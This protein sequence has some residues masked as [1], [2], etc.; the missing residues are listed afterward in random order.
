MT[1]I[2][3]RNNRSVAQ[4]RECRAV[5]M[6]ELMVSVTLISFIILTLYQMFNITQKQ[7]RR[8]MTQVDTLE[9]GRVAKLMLETDLKLAAALDSSEVA[10]SFYWSTNWSEH[11]MNLT[12]VTNLTITSPV[13]SNDIVLVP[14]WDRFFI[15]T[16]DDT[17]SPNNK[18]GVGYHV[19]TPTNAWIPPYNGMGTL[20]RYGYYTNQ[21]DD[22]IWNTFRTSNSVDYMSRV[23]DNVIHFKV[24]PYPT[25]SVSTTGLRAGYNIDEEGV[26]L[27]S[28][29]GDNMPTLVEIELGYLDEVTAKQALALG[30]NDAAKAFISSRPEKVTLFRFL[31]RVKD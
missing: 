13:Q 15:N 1:F 28:F 17:L 26:Q 16:E 6:I 24:K 21:F 18:G 9:S 25:D 10:P 19:G 5:T 8:A 7:L 30:D 22:S 27:H 20:Y 29:I 23:I 3:Y 12:P 11:V 4:W 31:V 2:R 14:S